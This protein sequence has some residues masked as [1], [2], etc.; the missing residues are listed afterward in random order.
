MEPIGLKR[1]YDLHRRW[2]TEDRIAG[3]LLIPFILNT[4]VTDTED[5]SE[6]GFLCPSV[7]W[8]NYT[9]RLSVNKAPVLTEHGRTQN[10]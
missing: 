6:R 9:C 3:L 1:Q 10:F 5:T 7:N 2:L 8:I 4:E